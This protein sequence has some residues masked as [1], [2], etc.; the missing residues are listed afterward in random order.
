M[1]IVHKKLTSSKEDSKDKFA[2]LAFMIEVAPPPILGVTHPPE[3]AAWPQQLPKNPYH[4]SFSPVPGRRQGEQGLPAPG[5]STA[6]Y[7][8]TPFNL[9]SEGEQ[10]A[11]H[12]SPEHQNVY[13][14]PLQWLTNHTKL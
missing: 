14:L 3:G 7:L 1:H 8:Q 2:V 5:G 13:L 11:G 12:A 10:F 6:Q 4:V 9:Y